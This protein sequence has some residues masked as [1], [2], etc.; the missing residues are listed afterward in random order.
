LFPPLSANPETRH[1]LFERFERLNKVRDSFKT[2]NPF[3][4]FK[5]SLMPVP[6]LINRSPIVR[7]ISPRARRERIIA[8]RDRILQMEFF[9]DSVAAMNLDRRVRSFKGHLHSPF[10]AKAAAWK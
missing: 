6:S 3:K 8:P 7:S 9:A 1:E 4:Q 10:L 2:F 5:P